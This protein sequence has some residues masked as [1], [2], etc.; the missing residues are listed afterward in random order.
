MYKLPRLQKDPEGILV[1]TVLILKDPSQVTREA[2][3]RVP[4]IARGLCARHLGP[5]GLGLSATSMAHQQA[6]QSL[7]ACAFPP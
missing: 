4:V 5:T 2:K 3:V 1:S 7:W 6:A